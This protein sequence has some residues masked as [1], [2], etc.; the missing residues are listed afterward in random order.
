M[1]PVATSRWTTGPCGWGTK[2]AKACVC[3]TCACQL[4]PRA[5]PTGGSGQE[6]PV[7]RSI[8]LN[9]WL[10]TARGPTGDGTSRSDASLWAATAC[11]WWRR[12]ARTPSWTCGA[13]CTLA[14]TTERTTGGP[15]TTGSTSEPSLRRKEPRSRSRRSIP[16]ARGVNSAREP[17][18]ASEID[19]A[20]V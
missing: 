1:K 2:D 17:R 3:T 10:S 5:D 9:P 12:L 18:G 11:W 14:L 16:S 15:S 4:A 6:P 7:R 13:R 19:A 8:S 20:R